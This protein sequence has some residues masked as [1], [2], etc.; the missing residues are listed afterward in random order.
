MV[1]T[2]RQAHAAPLVRVMSQWLEHSML[3]LAWNSR[4][5]YARWLYA[6]RVITAELW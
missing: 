5:S 3:I 2:M 6:S 1:I 4:N